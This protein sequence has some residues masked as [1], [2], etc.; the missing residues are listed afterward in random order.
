MIKNE[1]VAA[2]PPPNKV[3]D[4]G[5]GTS[6]DSVALEIADLGPVEGPRSLPLDVGSL[7]PQ[8]VF[9]PRA[10]DFVQTAP[11]CFRHR[12]K[13]AELKYHGMLRDDVG[14]P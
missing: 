7:A 13:S 12:L 4:L 5:V 14:R 6:S 3:T 2:V 1:Q 11:D 8:S 10:S 9:Q